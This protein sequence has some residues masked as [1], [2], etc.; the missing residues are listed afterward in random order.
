MVR[1]QTALGGNHEAARAATELLAGS[2]LSPETITEARYLR[3][4]AYLQVNENDNALADFQFLSNDTRSIYGAEARSSWPI[5]I[6]D[7]NHMIG[8]KHR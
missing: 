6:T 4:K 3:G 2:N 5:P 7:G 8:P 1:T